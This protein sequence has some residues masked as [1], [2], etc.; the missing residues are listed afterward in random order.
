MMVV[1]SSDSGEVMEVLFIIVWSFGLR[2]SR[3][4]MVESSEA[5]EFTE[6][7]FKS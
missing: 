1:E 4:K 3:L 5:A 2:S 6:I 7:F